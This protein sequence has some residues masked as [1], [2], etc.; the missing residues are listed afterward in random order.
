MSLKRKLFFLLIFLTVSDSLTLISNSG[1]SLNYFTA[2]VILAE[3]A[4]LYIIFS[5]AKKSNW[6]AGVPTLMMTL[7]KLFL[8]WNIVTIIRGGVSA[9]DYWDWKFLLQKSIFF[10][11][12]PFAF[13]IGK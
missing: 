2:I 5:I 6:S 10:F 7:L 8:I 11:L 3:F 1:T 13:F 4:A 12:I 9:V